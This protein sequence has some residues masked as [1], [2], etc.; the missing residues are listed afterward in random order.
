MADD[1]RPRGREKNIT[2]QGTGAYRRG[3]GTGSGPIGNQSGYSGRT[4]TSQSYTTATRASLG[5]GKL[6]S[7]I[8]AVV[9]VLIGG[10]T[11]LGGLVSNFLGGGETT[12]PTNTSSGIDLSSLS[13]LLSSFTSSNV[14]SGWLDI[15][16][17]ASSLNTSVS[18]AARS[19]Y[20]AVKGGGN[21]TVT[22][23][24]YMCGTDLESKSGM[25][26]N[27]LKEMANAALSDKVNI[28]VET[29]GCKEWKTSGISNTV[30]QIY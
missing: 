9:V 1:N 6:I 4:G 15:A 16:N 21:D 20:T 22:L 13:G 11:G 29:G 28:I 18:S 14:S 7:I 17:N 24:V 19:K 12:T 10:G 5:K 23:M 25:A 26:S 8:I 3:P 27:D 30:N 2:G